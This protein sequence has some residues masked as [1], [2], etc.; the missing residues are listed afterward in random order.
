LGANRV[1]VALEDGAAE[2][3]QRDDVV[4]LQVVGVGEF[5][6]VAIDLCEQ[7]MFG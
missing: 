6:R 1:D 2:A 7:E 4:L 5:G 3:G